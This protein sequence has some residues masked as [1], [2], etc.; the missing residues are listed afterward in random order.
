MISLAAWMTVSMSA[1]SKLR[2]TKRP[3]CAGGTGGAVEG[4]GG[5][6]TGVASGGGGGEGGTVRGPTDAGGSDGVVGCAGCAGAAAMGG[7][8]CGSGGFGRWW[9]DAQPEATTIS[10]RVATGRLL[11]LARAPPPLPRRV[12]GNWRD[13]AAEA[14]R[15]PPERDRCR[16]PALRGLLDRGGWHGLPRDRGRSEGPLGRLTRHGARHRDQA[17]VRKLS[18][19][20]RLAGDGRLAR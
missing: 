20:R 13:P 12:R 4:G 1:L 6:G 7:T 2:T 5:I 3:R 8:S 17:L 15:G 11:L 10:R 18:A 19:C 14:R 9:L 16:R